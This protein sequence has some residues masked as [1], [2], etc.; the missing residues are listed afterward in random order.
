MIFKLRRTTGRMNIK[1]MIA[2][3]TI[4]APPLPIKNSTTPNEPP[5]ICDAIVPKLTTG[6]RHEKYRNNIAG[7]TCCIF[8]DASV[9]SET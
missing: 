3:L 8:V 5:V 1:H 7:I 2:E 9:Q 4:P 6:A